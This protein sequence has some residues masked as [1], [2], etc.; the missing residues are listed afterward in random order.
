MDKNDI[1]ASVLTILIVFLIVGNIV[2]TA[3]IASK[4]REIIQC[5]QEQIESKEHE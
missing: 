2:K 3:K 5:Y 1:I 4:D